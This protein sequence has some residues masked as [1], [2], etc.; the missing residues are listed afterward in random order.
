[1]V[2]EREMMDYTDKY[3]AHNYKRLPLV[4]EKAKG[5][6]VWDVNGRMYMD[7]LVTYGANSLGHNHPRIVRAI[8]RYLEGGFVASMSGG[9]YNVPYAKLVKALAEFC[10]MDKVILKSGGSEAFEAAIKLTRRW[11]YQVKGIRSGSAE[12]IVAKDCFHGRMPTALAASSNSQ[13]RKDFG[14]FPA[15][16]RQ[17]PFGDPDALGRAINKNTA[18]FVFEPIQGEGGINVPSDGCLR[19]Y[20]KICRKNNVL[21]ITDEIQTGLGR[22]GYKFAYEHEGIKPDILVI[23]KTLSGGL[24]PISA[25]LADNPIMNL[26]GPG[27]EGSTFGSHPLSCV[28][29]LE[30]LSVLED[31]DLAQHAKVAGIYFRQRLMVLDSPLIE[32]V[33]GRGLMVGIKLSPKANEPKYYCHKLL[34]EGIICEKAGTDVVRFSPPLNIT[35]EEISMAIEKISKVFPRRNRS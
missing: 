28:A 3:S 14:P 19:E 7:M 33:K 30:V 4:A 17:I 34:D 25:V 6:W 12:I 26:I 13:Y 18:G 15:G 27:D 29:A 21:L 9:F 5:I 31:E 1:M 23:A 2:S 20:E 35:R 11:G 22:T 8:Q 24:M 10:G 16:V 32:E